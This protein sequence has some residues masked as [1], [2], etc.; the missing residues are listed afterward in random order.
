MREPRVRRPASLR[1]ALLAL[2]LQG[3]ALHTATGQE[4]P[5]IVPSDQEVVL[6]RADRARV[7]GDSAAPI[8]IVEISDFQCPFCARFYEDSWPV[9]DSLY[10][11][12][13]I[14]RYLWISFPNSTHPR[15]WPA[16]EAAFCAGAAGRFWPMH[17]ILF[18]RT[19]DWTRA[20]D[21]AELFTRWA[22]EIGVD[23]ESFAACLRNDVTAPLQVADYDSAVRSGITSTPFFVVGDSIAIRGAVSTEQFRSAVDSVLA[24]RGLEAPRR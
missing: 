19:D 17:D 10:V 14:A 1:P 11:R 3:F 23:G 16:V 15:A 20:A 6:Q 22:E 8:R 21:P 4:P 5:R 18:E 13:G 9:I 7:K 12:S 24:A 2:V